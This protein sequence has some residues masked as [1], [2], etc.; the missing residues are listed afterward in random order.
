MDL[1]DDDVMVGIGGTAFDDLA[2]RIGAA[3]QS[4]AALA[5]EVGVL[6]ERL[7]EQ[8]ATH[9]R[10]LVARQKADAAVVQ[11]RRDVAELRGAVESL[12]DQ[13]ASRRRR[14]GGCH[15]GGDDDALDA[16]ANSWDGA[17]AAPSSAL[18]SAP[19]RGR[20]RNSVTL[21]PAAAAAPLPPP[22]EAPTFEGSETEFVARL[23]RCLDSGGER[24]WL[25]A[26]LIPWKM[27]GGGGGG[28]NGDGGDGGDGDGGGGDGGGEP[29]GLRA[30]FNSGGCAGFLRALA[31][32]GH[33]GMALEVE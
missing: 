15:G 32:A 6:Q 25:D 5:E 1:L 31:A 17:P 4:R 12:L 24:S 11:L 23:A 30:L 10:E 19:A 28:G 18:P 21:R 13:A 3:E 2:L 27:Q 29:N 14:G 26:S 33:S 7:A 20:A 22:V 9:A 8:E 16:S